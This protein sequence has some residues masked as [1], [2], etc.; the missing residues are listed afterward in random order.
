MCW[1]IY[2]I[3]YFDGRF[4]G[5]WNYS[6]LNLTVRHQFDWPKFNSHKLAIYPR[7][8]AYGWINGSTWRS[9]A[10]KYDSDIGIYVRNESN[11][12]T[13]GM[14]NESKTGYLE[15]Y[16]IPSR[17]STLY[18]NWQIYVFNTATDYALYMLGWIC[19]E[20]CYI[21]KS[22]DQKEQYWKW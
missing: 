16:E 11:R 8:I 2:I 4:A 7:D 5:T 13:T 10:Y 15:L 18:K 19:I 12:M 14:L 3:G 22:S 21:D 1:R 6:K 9:L 20:W 17:H